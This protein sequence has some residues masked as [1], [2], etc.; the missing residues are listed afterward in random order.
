IRH[1]GPLRRRPHPAPAAGHLPDDLP[2]H[3]RD[4][5]PPGQHERREQ[6]M[7]HLAGPAPDPGHEDPHADARVPDIPP[8]PGPE[9]HRDGARRAV[10]TRELHLPAGRR[11]HTGRQRAR[12]YDGHG[13]HTASDPSSPPRP[14]DARRDPSRSGG[15]LDHRPPGTTGSRHHERSRPNAQPGCSGSQAVNTWLHERGELTSRVLLG[16]PQVRIR[17]AAKAIKRV[18]GELRILT[19]RNWGVSM[20][21]RI[22][23]INRFTTGW[24]GYFR[25]ADSEGTFR[26]LDGWI[27][28]RLR[29]IRWKEWKSTAAK[30]HNLRIR[31]I[32]ERSARKW[33]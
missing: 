15:Q 24:V 10:R 26:D 9:H 30:R 13:R 3:L 16:G 14:N 27:R 23:K 21:Y 29:Q 25:L 1:P 19:R 6:G 4:I 11:I 28:R 33:A 7:T 12:P 17:V 31:G 22:G 2:D 18:K 5:Q 32:S 8:V 20:E